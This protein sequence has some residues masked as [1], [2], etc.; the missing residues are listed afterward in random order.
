MRIKTPLWLLVAVLVLYGCRPELD[1]KEPSIGGEPDITLSGGNLYINFSSSDGTALVNLEASRKWNASFVNERA[2][3]WCSLS[4]EKGKRGTA[5]ILI[6]VKEN[7]D[8]DERSA[9][10]NFVCGDVVRTIIVTQKQ[11]DALLVSGDRFDVGKEGGRIEIEISSNVSFRYEV[12]EDA[13][14]WIK[15][16][17]TKGL[18]TSVVVFS[19]AANE[20]L[21]KREGKIT[22]SSSA[23]TEVV[24]VY[25][26]CE[27]PTIILSSDNIELEADQRSFS[28]DVRSNL[29]VTFTIPSECQWIQEV[30]TKSLSTN[31]FYFSVDENEAF[32]SRNSKIV[33]KSE[34]WGVEEAV[35][36]VQHA[37][38]PQ[39]ILGTG[40]YEYGPE[41]GAL[42]IVLKSNYDVTASIPDSCA[43]IRA[44]ETKALT[45]KVFHF[46]VDVNESFSKREGAIVFFNSLLNKRE[47]V[48]VRQEADVPTIIMGETSYD[49][50]AK[51]GPLNITLQSNFGVTASIPDSCAWIRAVET[52]ALTEKVFHFTVDVNESFSKREGAIVFF[53]SLLNKRETVI[54][55]Q[56]ADVP[57]II[58]GE[59]SY[60]FDA[61]GGPLNIE[62]TSNMVLDL[63]IGPPSCDWIIPITTKA[64]TNREHSFSVSK[65]HGRTGRQGWIVFRNDAQNYTDTVFVNQA[66]QPILASPH[67]TLR[68]SGRGWTVSFETVGTNPSDY[69]IE[70][71]DNWITL[72]SQERIPNGS[73][74]FLGVQEAEGTTNRDGRVNVY[75]NDY[76]VP[77]TVLVR[78]YGKLPSFSFTTSSRKVQLPVIEGDNQFGFVFWGDGANVPFLADIFHEYLSSGMHTVTVE[79]RSKKR[80]SFTGLEDGMTINLRELRNQ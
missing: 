55:R 79:V 52:K 42:D 75:F 34:E 20:S 25:Q 6:F 54:V 44:V 3:D 15:P 37:A 9:S 39:L 76:D 50:D 74:F 27:T 58:M 29:D 24:R 65:N 1:F 53:N 71:K 69:R 61:K 70:S 51:G 32:T 60:D 38:I 5:S 18:T 46:T 66:F 28:V 62:L 22:F 36:V 12:S 67:D 26:D 13:I 45:D 21:H 8:Y 56:E 63:E 17:E 16:L 77:D 10:I 11:K 7:M 49:F 59:T 48:I 47:T 2:R 30:K 31:T 72:M 43:W 14:N 57:T 68:A 40:V 41:G 33:F 73:R 64:L 4:L 23:G 35:E 80:V 78:Q 19:V